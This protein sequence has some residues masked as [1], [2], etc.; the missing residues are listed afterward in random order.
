VRFGSGTHQ[1]YRALGSGAFWEPSIEMKLLK[2]PESE[3]REATGGS[4]PRGIL[5]RAGVGLAAVAAL[6]AAFDA[7]AAAPVASTLLLET[8]TSWNG[9]PITFPVTSEPEV[10]MLV[11]DIAAG[12]A[13]PWHKHPVS[14]FAYVLAGKLR[15]ELEDKKAHDFKAGDAFGEVVDTWH[16]GVNIGS[17]PVKILVLYTGA[18][19]TPISIPQPSAAGPSH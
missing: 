8:S 16:R 7:I 6:V 10:Q 9:A 14:S 3:L 12:A 17:E 4:L 1:V 11:V 13:T 15:V 2:G 5:Y 18:K 19:G